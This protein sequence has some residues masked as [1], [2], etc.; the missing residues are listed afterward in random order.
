MPPSNEETPARRPRADRL[1]CEHL[2]DPLG[3]D[4][5]A[6]AFGWVPTGCQ[7]AYQ[8]RVATDPDLLADGVGDAWDSGRVES[9]EVNGV[10]YEG[11]QLA[12][13][14]RYWW[15]VRLWGEGE[16]PGPF[17]P[18]ASFEMGLLDPAYWEA[19]WI[20]GGEDVSSPLLRVGFDV[21]GKVR[22]ARA[23]VAALGYYELRLNGER[24][25]DQVLDPA[26]TSYD[27][28][29]DLY[30]GDGMPARIPNPRVLYSTFDI[31]GLLKPGANATGL[32]LGHGWYSAESDIGPGPLPRTPYA[33]RPRALLQIEIETLA[34][35]RMLTSGNGAA[36]AD[37]GQHF[38]GW[39]RIKVSGPA[40]SEVVLRHFG[41]LGDGGEPDDDA[42]INAWLPARQTDTY[43]VKG[44]GEEVWEPRFTL[45]GFRYVEITTPGPET[46]VLQV[47]GRVVHSDLPRTGEFTCSDAL[48]NQ[49]HRNVLWTL[50]TSFQGFPQ[51]AAERY[52]RV[53]WVG[54]PGWAVEDYLYDF[55]AA[56]FWLKWLDDL[57]DTQL[58]DGRF[59][60][61]C[62]I[63]W[64]GK[65]AMEAPDGYDVPDDFG[66]SSE[67]MYRIATRTTFPSWGDQVGRGATTIWETWGGDPTFSRNMKLLAT[68]GKFLYNEVAGL[69][70][71]A[72]GWR[73]I[74]VRP[75]LIHRL[76]HARASVRT[77]RG[78]ASIDWR[79]DEDGLHMTLE[80]PPASEAEVQVPCRRLDAP[81]LT[82]DGVLVT[83]LRRDGDRL[84]LTVGGGVHRFHLTSEG[85]RA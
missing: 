1:R 74:L 82:R 17:A 46:A 79:A 14:R 62:P 47:E 25:G 52:E 38:S 45:H 85:S 48:L 55:D 63:H 69:T 75:S 81:R 39:T 83:D 6:P 78:D 65:I 67:V 58:P 9:D 24:V 56:R 41:E 8:V 18:A 42:N 19:A 77:V 11:A 51:D 12:S 13:R 27:H 21:P 32:I 72:P 61:I 22:R 59:P 40:G 10:P 31:T 16:E 64:R 29:P 43:V 23:H 70:P 33:D 66:E 44:G 36:I 54:D 80:V 7:R 34:P 49:I 73:R 2:D 57:A 30:D 35:A 50:R 20:G 28:D 71:A 76:T 5:A 53:G 37:F 4:V 15:S 84:V 68:I 26:N 60:L 3:I